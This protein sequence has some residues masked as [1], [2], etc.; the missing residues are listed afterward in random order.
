MLQVI[1]ASNCLAFQPSASEP[2]LYR[3]LSAI[4]KGFKMNNYIS[5]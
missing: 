3:L 4:V 2:E 1:G 5:K